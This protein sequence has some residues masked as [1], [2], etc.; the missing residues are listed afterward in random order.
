MRDSLKGKAAIITGSTSGIGLGLA[1]AL[2]AKGA[3]IM[4]NGFGDMPEIERVRSQIS[5]EH[6]VRA[7]YSSADM[8]KAAQIQALIAEAERDLGAVDI[9]STMPASSTS[10][11]WT[12]SRWRSGTRSWR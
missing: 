7:L 8:S 4:L 11:R 1:Q 6:G 2:A 5:N 10:R 12:N 3:D 9:W